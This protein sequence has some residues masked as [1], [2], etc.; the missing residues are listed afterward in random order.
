MTEFA[1]MNSKAAAPDESVRRMALDV[2]RS[3][4]VQA[5]AGSGKTQLLTQRFLALLAEAESPDEIVAI[6]FTKAAA[7][8]MRHRILS[9]LEA[10]GSSAAAGQGKEMG[11]PGE[12]T[13]EGAEL[14]ALKVGAA[15]L[16]NADA[17]GWQLLEQPAQLRIMTID[18]FCRSM[19]SQ[20]PLSWGPLAALGGELNLAQDASRHYR[21]AARR[22]LQSLRGADSERRRSVEA[23]LLWRDNNWGNVEQLIVDMLKVRNRWHQEFV[24]VLDQN[25]EALRKRLEAPFC[26]AARD[27][28]Q[29]VIDLLEA[30]PGARERAHALGK[31]ACGN[32]GLSRWPGWARRESLPDLVAREAEAEIEV[33]LQDAAEAYHEL[34]HFLT[35]TGKKWRSKGGLNSNFGFP[36]TDEGRAQKDLFAR[37]IED[38]RETEGL[39]RALLEMRT[40]IS[41]RYTEEEWVLLRHCF[42]VLRQSAG[43]LTTIFAEQR[44]VDFIQVTRMALDFLAPEDG[45]PSEAAMAQANGI[46]HLLIDEFQDTSRDQHEL[47]SRLIGAWPEREGRTCFCVGDPMQSIYGFR[48]AE[49]ELFEWVKKHG[50]DTRASDADSP[51]FRFE[52]LLLKANF[53][54]VPSLVNDLNSRFEPIFAQGME[55]R[56]EGAEVEFSEAVAAR[57]SNSVAKVELHLAFTGE[58]RSVEDG[59]RLGERVDSE[60][61]REKQLEEM[62]KLISSRLK[63]AQLSSPGEMKKYRLAVLGLKRSSLLPVAEALQRAGIR[64][65]AVELTRLHERPEVLDALAMARATMNPTDRL[66]WMGLLRAPW[67]GLSLAELYAVAGGEDAVLLGRPIPELIGTRLSALEESGKISLRSRVAVEGVAGVVMRANARRGDAAGVTLG[68]WLEGVWKDLGGEAT[69]GAAERQ[70]LAALWRCIDELGGGEVDL[71]G[72]ALNSAMERLFASPD[73]D[74]SADFGVQLMTIHKSKGLEFEV[75]VVPDLE[76]GTGRDRPSLLSWLERVA[77]EGSEEL[78]EFLIAPIASKGASPGAARSWVDSIRRKREVAEQRRV[79]YVAATR[80]REE[81]HLFARPRFKEVEELGKVSR[82]LVAPTG[83]MASAWPGIETEVLELFEA[84]QGRVTVREEDFST[85]LDLAAEAG[86]IAIKVHRNVAEPSSSKLVVLDTRQELAGQGG[87][88]PT[89]VRRLAERFVPAAQAR[90]LT[91]AAGGGEGIPPVQRGAANGDEDRDPS[92]ARSQYARTKGGL[93]SRALGVAVHAL[94]EEASVL[95]MQFDGRECALRLAGALPRVAAMARRT[96]IA[97]R[98]SMAL[99]DRA[100][101][102]VRGSLAN[103]TGAWILAPHAMAFTEADWTYRS[104]NTKWNLRP[105]RV[106][107]AL[108]PGAPGRQEA[109]WI[110]DY[111][112]AVNTSKA[113]ALSEFLA[114]HREYYRGQLAAYCEVFRE[115]LV[116]PATGPEGGAA[117]VFVGIYY[118]LLQTLDFWEP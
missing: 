39:E 90:V 9:V 100:L 37:L 38:L 49:V 29:R 113:V 68:T 67:C 14:E 70:N 28:L 51:P 63:A 116:A 22:T 99:A 111:K 94:L 112:S 54:T 98:E 104:R 69:V 75:V 19:A 84:W 97:H 53:R 8:E 10:A 36:L 57:R 43:E 25:W 6:T 13:E 64:Y 40:P 101:E 95:R 33:L 42:E 86:E 92:V 88:K 72:A 85:S 91:A 105:D 78:T 32:G 18:S 24:Y 61:T 106:F 65:R 16:G 76:S 1:E 82:S 52:P 71:R 110:I 118:P 77:G 114:E 7:A 31:Y 46:R 20:S 74:A 3:F 4:L 80:A 45:Q 89:R 102:V 21:E 59:G 35:T 117:K 2:R 23:L 79:L 56:R 15:V 30:V 115:M 26:R 87:F 17:R 41:T 81:L 12:G 48:E 44:E 34:A 108:P 47:L 66:A 5:P 109:W 27:R 73:P 62:V 11:D 107:R 103:E 55:Y 96:G 83:L 93:T 50:I 60:W 58:A